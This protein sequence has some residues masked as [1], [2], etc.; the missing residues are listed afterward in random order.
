MKSYGLVCAA[1]LWVVFSTSGCSA[2]S[3]PKPQPSPSPQPLHS[4]YIPVDR[5]PGSALYYAY[6]ESANSTAGAA[7][8]PSTAAVPILLWLQGGPGCAS[9]FGAF[10]ELGPFV[11]NDKGKLEP[12]PYAWNNNFGLL[13][14]D[15]PVG[16][17]ANSLGCIIKQHF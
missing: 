9:T 5:K 13:V 6:W 17:L 7:D 8:E 12:N 14:I 3:K 2:K 11:I 4:G 16:E 1:V 10:Y 15:Q